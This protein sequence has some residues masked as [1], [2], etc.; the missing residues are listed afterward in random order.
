M[1]VVSGLAMP[2]MHLANLTRTMSG[3]LESRLS[4]YLVGTR[5]A[6]CSLTLV[7]VCD[8]LLLVAD[9]CTDVKFGSERRLPHIE[10]ST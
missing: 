4:G 5:F 7:S 3:I 8:S 1:H 2:L 6:W 10:F 9:T